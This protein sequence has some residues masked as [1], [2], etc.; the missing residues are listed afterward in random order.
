MT[1]YGKYTKSQVGGLLSLS[2]RNTRHIVTNGRR[3]LQTALALPRKPQNIMNKFKSLLISLTLFLCTVR[4]WSQEI[5]VNA[6][7]PGGVYAIGEKIAWHVGVQGEGAADIHK[8]AYVLLKDGLT[9][10]G[11]G[12]LMLQENGADLETKLHEP[13]AVLAEFS[14]SI[15]DKPE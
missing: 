5:T 4:G 15:P 14:A 1:P 12:E 2:P 10:T 7:K 8:V 13:G 11:R 3:P 9:E 6:V